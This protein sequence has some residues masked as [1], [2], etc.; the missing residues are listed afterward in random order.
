MVISSSSQQRVTMHPAFVLHTRLYRDSSLIVELL[1]QQ[2]GRISAVARG[3]RRAKSAMRGLLTPFLPL[4]VSWSGRS[5]LV[6]LGKVES[7]A[8]PFMFDGRCLICGKSID[9]F[10]V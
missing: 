8:S 3:A 9:R 4:L 2:H 10:I 6:T 7:H 5:E 1:T